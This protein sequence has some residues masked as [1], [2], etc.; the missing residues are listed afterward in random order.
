MTNCS[1]QERKEKGLSLT[2]ETAHGPSSGQADVALQVKVRE[3]LDLFLVKLNL[4]KIKFTILLCKK[5][6]AGPGGI[7][8]PSNQY[9]FLNSTLNPGNKCHPSFGLKAP[10][11]FGFTGIT[12]WFDWCDF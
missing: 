1:L 5:P 3:N 2:L 4:N 8:S 7:Y 11:I 10:F 9:S 6:T 12:C